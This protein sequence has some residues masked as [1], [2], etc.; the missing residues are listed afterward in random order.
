[1]RNARRSVL[2]SGV[3]LVMGS[4]LILSPLQAAEAG[5]IST[6]PGARL[7]HFTVAQPVWSAVA[8][9]APGYRL[10]GAGKFQ[11]SGRYPAIPHLFYYTVNA[12]KPIG[13]DRY[14]TLLINSQTGMGKEQLAELLENDSELELLRDSRLGTGQYSNV[15]AVRYRSNEKS[16]WNYMLVLRLREINNQ[17][18]QTINLQGGLR[19]ADPEEAGV[20]DPW[21]AS[22]AIDLML[23]LVEPIP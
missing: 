13:N 17:D 12:E 20:P 15:A 6:H 5:R 22:A 2:F 9:A 3:I 16:H 8:D 10:E 19:G 1:M 14:A 11:N 4:S 7:R 23:K 18:N 21:S